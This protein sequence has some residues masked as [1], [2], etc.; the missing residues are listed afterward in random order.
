MIWGINGFTGKDWGASVEIM[1]DFAVVIARYSFVDNKLRFTIIQQI[2]NIAK[3]VKEF[4]KG[5]FD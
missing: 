3:D 4:F 2:K 5:L 1:L